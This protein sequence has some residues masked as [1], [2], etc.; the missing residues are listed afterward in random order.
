MAK[1]SKLKNEGGA[2]V[3]VQDYDLKTLQS[4]TAKTA[5]EVSTTAQYIPLQDINGNI[6]KISMQSMQEALRNVLGSLL[7]NNDKGTSITGIAG[8]SGSGANID[9]GSITP[10]NLA[11]LLGAMP[12]VSQQNV[13][14][15]DSW[16]TYSLVYF[17]DTVPQVGTF[18]YASN[19]L[20]MT[21][22]FQTTLG[23]NH[24]F[25]I[26]IAFSYNVLKASIRFGDTTSYVAWKEFIS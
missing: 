25:T 9:F 15:I 11:S 26:Q 12:Y 2:A 10:A 17:E 22:P 18:P 3:E 24:R 23:F 13:S 20:V 5:S 21:I 16:F 8:L 1:V 6:V 14:N 19:I 4:Q 7:I